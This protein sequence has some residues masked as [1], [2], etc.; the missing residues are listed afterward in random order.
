[1]QSSL[2]RMLVGMG[3]FLTTLIVAVAGYMI[4]GWSFLDS[5]YQ[6]VIT[7]FGVGFGEIGPMTPALRI[8]TMGVI[9]AG[10]TSVA[11]ILGGFL[12]MITEG[13]VK[14]ALGVRR[15]IRDID[16]LHNHVIICGYGRIGQILA[17]KMKEAKHPFVL[18]DSDPNRVAQA[19]AEGYLVQQGS[20]T[21]ESVLE[22]VGIQRARFLAT[23]LP[24]DAANVFITLTARSLNPSLIILARGEY[25]S[26]EKKLLQAGA[27]RVVS[28]AAI[29]ALRMSHMIT[30]PASL[31][32]LDQSNGR[33]TLNELLAQINVQLDELVIPANSDLMGASIGTVEVRGRGS[34][35]IVALRRAEGETIV[36]PSQD[37]FLHEG[38][39]LIVMGHRGDIPQFAKHHALKRQ[40]QYRGAKFLGK[41]K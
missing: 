30:H 10:C 11:Y 14:R 3:F 4:A 31:D 18:I 22:V 19:E 23:V 38:D 21:D 41:S 28:P 6:V 8:F 16:L 36:H 9:V 15:M 25:L 2:T 33:E 34:F 26:T 20:A 27:D 17:R 12:Q 35:I 1:M 37:I 39:T 7:V 13:E 24:D 29:G 5:V 40:M 32:F